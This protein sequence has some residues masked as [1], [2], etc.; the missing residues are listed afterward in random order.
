[1]L[2]LLAI[3]VTLALLSIPVALGT[4]AVMWHRAAPAPLF[5]CPHNR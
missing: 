4:A 5:D 2:T 3:L 1:M